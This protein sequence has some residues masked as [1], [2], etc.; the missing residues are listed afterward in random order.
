MGPATRRAAGE[1]IETLGTRS[2]TRKRS[3]IL[4]VCNLD[5]GKEVGGKLFVACGDAPELLE[6]QYLTWLLK[7]ST[8]RAIM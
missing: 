8:Y 2:W 4:T 5:H 1:R 6:I 3:R 7:T